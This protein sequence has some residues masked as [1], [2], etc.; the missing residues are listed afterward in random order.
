MA[1]SPSAPG[2]FSTT[3]GLPQRPASFSAIMRAP[4]SVALPAPNGSRNLTDRCG[5]AWL[6]DCA[7][8]T[9]GAAQSNAATPA[10]IASAPIL[11]RCVEF[12]I[13]LQPISSQSP[14]IGVP[15]PSHR[16]C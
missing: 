12:D 7:A 1:S 11:L 8:A 16:Y 3:T 14:R 10:T 15:P 5:Q 6:E 9:V 2:L 13:G 4:A